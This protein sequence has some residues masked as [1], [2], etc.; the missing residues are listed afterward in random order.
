MGRQ[1]DTI[2]IY[3]NK[4]P[5]HYQNCLV[6]DNRWCGGGLSLSVF[7]LEIM[8]RGFGTKSRCWHG[9][10]NDGTNTMLIRARSN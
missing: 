1:C 5:D 3:S 2:Y 4:N 6:E 8:G 9:N 10:N 7:E